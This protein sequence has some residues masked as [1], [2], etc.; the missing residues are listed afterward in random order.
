MRILSKNEY[1][2]IRELS[3]ASEALKKQKINNNEFRE[4]LS[5]VSENL[6]DFS[7]DRI[8][9]EHFSF[10]FFNIDEI[11]TAPECELKDND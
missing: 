8:Y 11:I 7:S 3:K 1:V 5:F 6:D 4:Y 2:Y 9:E 10:Q